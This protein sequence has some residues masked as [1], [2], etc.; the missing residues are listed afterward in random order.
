MG[1]EVG[2]K[3]DNYIVR[4]LLS[5]FLSALIGSPS[6]FSLLP[7]SSPPFFA[8]FR[9]SQFHLWR[10]RYCQQDLFLV[11]VKAAVSLCTLYEYQFTHNLHWDS[12][13]P[14]GHC[15]SGQESHLLI[16]SIDF[17]YLQKGK[18]QLPQ[19]SKIPEN[20]SHLQHLHNPSQWVPHFSVHIWNVTLKAFL[21]NTSCC[22]TVTAAT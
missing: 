22:L 21:W 17:R 2:K 10:C 16:C 12:F 5:L 1:N 13:P 18:S 6:I 8:S 9:N 19:C 3:K 11:L 4:N 14:R 7:D 20:L 15:H